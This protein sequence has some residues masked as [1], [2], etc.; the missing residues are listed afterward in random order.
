MLNLP[1]LTAALLLPVTQHSLVECLGALRGGQDTASPLPLERQLAGGFQEGMQVG[2]VPALLGQ[3][4][5]WPPSPLD[6]S[7]SPQSV[8]LIVSGDWNSAAQNPTS[9]EPPHGL[10]W[11][12][13]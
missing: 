9:P 5:P 8:D 12:A 6:S 10:E 3:S 4:S 13:K 11:T 1:A 2:P 7:L